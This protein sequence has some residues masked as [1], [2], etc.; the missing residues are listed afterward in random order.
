MARTSPAILDDDEEIDIASFMLEACGLDYGAFFLDERILTRENFEKNFQF[1]TKMVESRSFR[2]ASYFVIGYFILITGAKMPEELRYEILEAAKFEHEIGCWFSK[3]HEIERKIYLKDFREK[4]SDYKSGQKLHPIQLIYFNG[5]SNLYIKFRSEVVI[6][7]KEFRE[8]CDSSEISKIKHILLQGWEL[9]TIPEQIFN[10]TELVS[11]SLEH[12]LIEQIPESISDLI[13]LKTLYLDYNQ[14]KIFPNSLIKVP[15]LEFLSL[16][17]NF[18]SSIPR[19]LINYKSLKELKIRLNN[20]R[21]LPN[22]FKSSKIKIE[23]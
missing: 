20:I 10:L 14:I 21:E 11:L 16:N 7:L 12:N 5:E 17:N 15:S 18:I 9:K 6:G 23:L 4:I 8:F 2:R 3:D 19:D 22:D 13:S 1:L